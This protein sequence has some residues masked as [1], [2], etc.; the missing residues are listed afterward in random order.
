M[1]LHRKMFTKSY[2]LPI[3]SDEVAVEFACRYCVVLFQ[4][5]VGGAMALPS[6]LG[7]QTG[8]ASSL[9]CHGALC[10]AGWEVQDMV[11]RLWSVLSG[12]EQEKKKNPPTI[13]ALV[14]LH[15]AMGLAMTIPMN[16]LYHDNV[17]YHEFVFLLQCAS[18][19]AM[20]MQSFGYTL[21]VKTA[22]GLR[23]MKLSVSVTWLAI[24][25]SRGV[26]YIVVGMELLRQS[27]RDGNMRM[28]CI[29]VVVL[30]AMGVMNG[31]FFVDATTKLR[32]FLPM[33]HIPAQEEHIVDSAE[34]KET[35]PC[36]IGQ[37]DAASR[38]CLDRAAIKRKAA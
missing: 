23:W 26:R 9:A 15:H 19:F 37:E 2:G 3:E 27:S 17:Y 38:R 8:L 34:P 11:S 13:F 22:D 14:C 31:I 30:G 29:G 24:V 33:S 4:H 35:L 1:D 20:I 25:W 21:D 5:V 32:K 18:A 6:V 28:F 7:W 10:E 36:L 12:D 16:L